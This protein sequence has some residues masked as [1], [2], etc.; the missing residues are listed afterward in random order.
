M[1]E[2]QPREVYKDPD[3][4][5]PFA[6]NWQGWATGEGAITIT[7][8][9]WESELEGITVLTSPPQTITDNIAVVWLEGGEND[10]TYPVKCTVTAGERTGV[11]RM[12]VNV[13]KR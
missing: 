12:M 3:E 7:A 11:R 6:E 8:A 5:L 4:R 10:T 1:H 13:R 9:D 2:D